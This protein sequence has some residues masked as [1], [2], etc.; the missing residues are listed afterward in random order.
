MV[1][2]RPGVVGV[3][4][5]RVQGVGWCRMVPRAAD[6]K[7][8]RIAWLNIACCHYSYNVFY[9]II[10]KLT[11]NVYRGWNKKYVKNDKKFVVGVKN[12]SGGGRKNKNP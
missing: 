1:G 5:G 8:Q 10:H 11:I 4:G 7:R 12:N 6:P 2:V 9:I 3:S